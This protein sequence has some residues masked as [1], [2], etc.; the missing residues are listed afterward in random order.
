MQLNLNL[1]E[2]PGP[3]RQVWENLDDEQ[4]QAVINKL[5]RL[6][7]KAVLETQTNEEDTDD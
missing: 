5:S 6:I 1:L 3:I 7:T 4:R 2:M